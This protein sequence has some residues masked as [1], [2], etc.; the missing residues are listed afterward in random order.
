MPHILTITILVLCGA[1]LIVWIGSTTL[2]AMKAQEHGFRLLARWLVTIGGVL[3]FFKSCRSNATVSPFSFLFDALFLAV[4]VMF[5]WGRNIAGFFAGFITSAFD[6]G[7]EELKP[8]PL[9]SI[10]EAKRKQGKIHE[11]MWAIQEQLEKFP[12]DF[13][14]QMLLAEIQ[15]E[16]AN[17]LAGADST[18]HRLCAQKHPP[19]RIA[20]AL[21]AL[22]DW[23]LRF[24]QDVDAARATFQEIIDRFPETDMAQQAENRIAHLSD[25]ATLLEG[26]EPR[27]IRLAVMGDT[28]PPKARPEEEVD[29]MA[30]AERLTRHLTEFPYDTEAREELAKLYADRF[31]KLELA[32]EQIEHLVALPN[33][34]PRHIARWLNLLADLQVRCTGDTALA[35]VSIQRIV[36]RF[37]DSAVAEAAR[38]RLQTLVLEKKRYEQTSAV[39]FTPR[40]EP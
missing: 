4:A 1:G 29:A 39:P 23:H 15:A 28:G 17:D 36:D 21:T 5:M 3:F 25:T 8:E 33:Q 30:E 40:E 9:Y 34:S 22:A 20:G 19:Q 35:G 12:G 11:A 13:R 10:A 27:T 16:N 38:Q 7:G 37:P 18:I 31:G 2:P 6:G 32:A 14:G 24:N 26:R